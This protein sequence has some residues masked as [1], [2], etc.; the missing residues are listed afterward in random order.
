M[1]P[2]DTTRN[3]DE[4][5]A[6]SR[7]NLDNI[8]TREIPSSFWKGNIRNRRK[9][10]NKIPFSIKNSQSCCDRISCNLWTS[11]AFEKDTS[12]R[13][14]L[15]TFSSTHYSIDIDIDLH[16][17]FI[18]RSVGENELTLNRIQMQC[19]YRFPF[20]INNVSTSCTYIDTMKFWGE[21]ISELIH[22][23]QYSE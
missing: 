14:N 2:C 5:I 10:C 16:Y 4:V 13:K 7:M 1:I 3:E 15:D 11:R 12:T 9:S 23:P 18:F 22:E 19:L 8:S 20:T 21:G 17:S 6:L